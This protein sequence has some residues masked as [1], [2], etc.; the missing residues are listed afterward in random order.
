[1]V[2]GYI[3]WTLMDN[4]EWALG[5]HARFGLA[6]TDFQTQERKERPAARLFAKICASNRL[7]IDEGHTATPKQGSD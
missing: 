6:A 4:F 1:M 2:L 5:R 7:I 3:Y